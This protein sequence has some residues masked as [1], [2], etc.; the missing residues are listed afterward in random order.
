MWQEQQEAYPHQHDIGGGEPASPPGVHEK[1]LAQDIINNGSV[2]L[3][4]GECRVKGSNALIR[5]PRQWPQ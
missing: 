2:R 5:E 1:T 4:A 3:H